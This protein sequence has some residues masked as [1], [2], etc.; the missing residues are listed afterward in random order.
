MAYY[1]EQCQYCGITTH[2]YD[3][4]VND[5]DIITSHNGDCGCNDQRRKDIEAEDFFDYFDD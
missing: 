1:H 4:G 5:G 3:D 2:R